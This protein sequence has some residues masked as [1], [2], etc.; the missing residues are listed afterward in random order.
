M[1]LRV[2]NGSS[3]VTAKTLRV[4]TGSAWD[5][6]DGGSVWNGSSWVDF[7]YLDIQTV[8]V[9]LFTSKT[10]AQYGYNSGSSTGS[11]SDGTFN[12]KGGATIVAFNWA[13]TGD[14]FLNI[15]GI[16]TNADWNHVNITNDYDTT[17]YTF[18]RADAGFTT[19]ATSPSRTIWQWTG[20]GN[21]FPYQSSPAVTAVARFT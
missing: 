17:E 13:S 8:T 9:G 5:P 21:P 15:S 19:V 4:W 10:G 12:P 2:W 6:A 18:A 3:W 20:V 11:I 14:L 16:H 1:P 7:L